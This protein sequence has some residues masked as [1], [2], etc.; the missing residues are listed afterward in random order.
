MGVIHLEHQK[1]I[2]CIFEL[3]F[4]LLHTASTVLGD[5]LGVVGQEGRRAHQIHPSALAAVNLDAPD[6]VAPAAG[7]AQ[8]LLQ[9]PSDA[10]WMILMPAEEQ[11]S[12]ILFQ[13]DRARAVSPGQ[14]PILSG[15]G[16][17]SQRRDILLEFLLL[18]LHRCYL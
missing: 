1:V 6:V 9:P 13:A 10:A 3:L 14:R 7:T 11:G 17:P 18:P 4:G 2:V 16:R 5:L 15:A 12:R 8:A